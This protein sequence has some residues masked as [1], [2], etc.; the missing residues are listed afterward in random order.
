MSIPAAKVRPQ[1]VTITALRRVGPD[2][3]NRGLFGWEG[4]VK[5]TGQWWPLPYSSR[6]SQ[7]EVLKALRQSCKAHQP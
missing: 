5:E 4:F 2:S 6:Q 7:D 1:R 3:T